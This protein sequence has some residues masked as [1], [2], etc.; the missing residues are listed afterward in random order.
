[1]IKFSKKR[2]DVFIVMQCDCTEIRESRKS[3]RREADRKIFLWGDKDVKFGGLIPRFV[4]EVMG[5]Q[6]I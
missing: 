1:M 6:T 4:V 3:F 5:N 2:A